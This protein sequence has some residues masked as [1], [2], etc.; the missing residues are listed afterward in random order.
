MKSFVFALALGILMTCSAPF[1]PAQADEIVETMLEREDSKVAEE[2]MLGLICITA[3]V[4]GT[5][6]ETR[7]Y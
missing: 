7:R 6:I 4:A 2:I 3:I 5:Y 1:E